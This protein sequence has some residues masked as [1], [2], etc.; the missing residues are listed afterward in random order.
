MI[1]TSGVNE[2]HEEEMGIE[3]KKN[4]RTVGIP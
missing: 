1:M 2:P 4:P 3:N